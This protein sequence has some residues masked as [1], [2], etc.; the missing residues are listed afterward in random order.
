MALEQD[1]PSANPSLHKLQIAVLVKEKFFCRV[2]EYKEYTTFPTPG[3]GLF[4]IG[5]SRTWTWLE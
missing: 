5:E 4:L 1:A 2:S 3:I